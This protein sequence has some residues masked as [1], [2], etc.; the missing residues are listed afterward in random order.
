MRFKID[1]NLPIEL[2]ETLRKA[3]FDAM[4]VTEQGMVG[5]SDDNL[6]DICCREGRT[7]VTFDLDFSDIR[8]YPP[9]DSP[10]AI[11]FRLNHQEKSYVLE[12][13]AK[14]IPRLSLE[15][16]A[17]HLWIVSEQGIRIRGGSD[18]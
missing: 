11:V 8:T 16:I 13:A 7:L 2:A 1:E 6:F 17:G 18:G 9:D 3:G 15:P 10:G 5:S 4:T 12:W 14:M